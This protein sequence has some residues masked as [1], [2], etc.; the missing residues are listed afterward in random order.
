[1]SV[2][3]EFPEF[4]YIELEHLQEIRQALSTVQTEVSELSLGVIY[5]YQKSFNFKATR[6]FGNICILGLIGCR[7]TFLSPIGGNRPRE[8]IEAI[9]KWLDAEYGDGEMVAV[10]ADMA[11]SASEINWLSVMD[12]RDDYDY[13]YRVKDLVKLSGQDYHSKKNFVQQF[14]KKNVYEYKPL[15]PELV[16]NCLDLQEKWCALRDC[17]ID[18][19]MSLENR[20]IFE[21]L[22]NFE[23]FG[24]FGGAIL[25]KGKVE[26]FTVGERLNKTTAV[27]HIEKANTDFRGIYQA[28]N[29]FFCEK[30]LNGYEFVNREQDL[31]NPGL[32]KAKL[33]YHPFRML[34]KFNIEMKKEEK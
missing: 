34:Q 2:I 22:H 24:L 33:S 13:I 11:K 14:K 15:A 26:A 12:D 31:G 5:G 17:H 32:R 28:V 16:R 4:K 23:K 3:P 30:E 27:V 6:L 8:T 29:N 1:M 7:P 20:M 21:L 25:I 9:F 18:E 10:P 19:S